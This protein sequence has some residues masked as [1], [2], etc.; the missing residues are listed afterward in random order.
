MRRG[1]RALTLA[2]VGGLVAGLTQ[3]AVPAPAQAALAPNDYCGGQCSDILPPG[4]NGNASLAD[5]L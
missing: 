5:I 3:V 4:E 1:I 2:A